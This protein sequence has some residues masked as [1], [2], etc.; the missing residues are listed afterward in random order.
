[1]S[2]YLV[3]YRKT[4]GWEEVV[5]DSNEH[6]SYIVDV[7]LNNPAVEEI[8]VYECSFVEHYKY[9]ESAWEKLDPET[10]LIIERV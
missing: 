3:R 9:R 7:E 5:C 8:E 10:K 1:M 6:M 4:S 2:K